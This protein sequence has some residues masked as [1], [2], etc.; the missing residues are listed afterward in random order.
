MRSGRAL[1]SDCSDRSRAARPCA[2]ISPVLT[3]ETRPAAALALYFSFAFSS[4]SR[5]ACS[6][7]RSIDELDR[8]LLPVGG[9]ARA[10]QV[11]K[12]V[13]V[14]PLLHAGDALVVDVDEADQ[15]RRR[16]R[17]SDR[18]ACSRAGSR[19]RECRA[20]DVLLLLRRDL[21]LQPDEAFARRQPLAHFGGVEIGQ[22][23]GQQLDRLVVVDDAARL[24]EQRRR[25]DVGRK[26]HAV[27]VDDVGPRG[28]DRVLRGGAARAVAVGADGE[29]HQP[30]ADHG[31][32]R[33]ER[34]DGKADAGAR[35]RVAVDIA[36][37]EQR[38][39]S[40][41][42]ARVPA[43]RRVAASRRSSLRLP[44]AAPSRSRSGASAAASMVS[45]IVPIGSGSPGLTKLGGR[46]RQVLQ[47]VVLRGDRAA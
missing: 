45:I 2:T 17:R 5:S 24:A 44:A 10:V 32:D 15:V 23:G 18:R 35:L 19:C 37:V 30:P 42:A 1:P 43:A 16:R 29:H 34:E 33:G 26:D 27:A 39:G 21:A 36:P 47:R 4:S 46:S 31:V 38:C 25:L 8:L 13:A 9:E 12:A 22:R 40:A 6:T 20:M 41:A 11:G 28:R 7:R 3:L 14:E